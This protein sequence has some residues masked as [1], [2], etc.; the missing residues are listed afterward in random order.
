MIATLDYR[1]GCPRCRRLAWILAVASLGT[2]ARRGGNPRTPV[3]RVV[4]VAWRGRWAFIAP[5]VHVAAVWLG[6]ALALG[7]V[8]R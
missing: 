3:Y 1:I 5:L 7:Q 4:G 8:V 6:L 2:I